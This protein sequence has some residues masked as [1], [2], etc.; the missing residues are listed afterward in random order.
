MRVRKSDHDRG[1]RPPHD[2]VLIFKTIP[3]RDQNTLSDR[4]TD[5]MAND[6]L[7]KGKEKKGVKQMHNTS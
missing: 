3:P 7:T 2:G 6:R 5:Y 1:G 4:R